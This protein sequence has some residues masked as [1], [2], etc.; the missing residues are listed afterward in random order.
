MKMKKYWTR[1]I[2]VKFLLM[3]QYKPSWA[4]AD[5]GLENRPMIWIFFTYMLN[6]WSY[7]VY[8]QINDDELKST[9]DFC[10]PKNLRNK[11]VLTF[12]M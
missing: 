12:D 3:N 6:V 9:L 4:L 1:L 7:V 8:Q 11:K 10:I 2:I 5:I